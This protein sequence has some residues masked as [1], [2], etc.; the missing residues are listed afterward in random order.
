VHKTAQHFYNS[1]TSPLLEYMGNDKTIWLIANWKA[2]K[3]VAEALEWVSIVG[4]QIERRDHLKVVICPTFTA[5][6]EV[7]K[8]VLVGNFNL[9]VGCQDLSAFEDGPYT[10]EETA[11][12]LKQFVDLAILGHSERRQNFGETP[13]MVSQKVKQAL[14][15]Q[16]I[17]LVC[18]QGQET[19]VPE[20]VKLIAFEPVE[21]IGTG[22]PDTPQDASEVATFFQQNFSQELDIVYGGSVT[23]ENVKGFLMPDNLNGVLVGGASLDP[24]EFLKIYEQCQSF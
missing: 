13:E 24:E 20:G 14:D 18:V 23:S 4:P 7:K 11:Q 21:A 2:N 6:E 17:P 5:I 10:G 16:I 9:M 12:I 22:H 1:L 3:T 8:A 15:H 19:P